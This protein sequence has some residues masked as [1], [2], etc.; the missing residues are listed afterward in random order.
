MVVFLDFLLKNPCRIKEDFHR[1]RGINTQITPWI[2][3]WWEIVKRLDT[4]GQMGYFRCIYHFRNLR[5]NFIDLSLTWNFICVSIWDNLIIPQPTFLKI[6]LTGLYRRDFISLK[7]KN[8]NYPHKRTKKKTRQITKRRK[9]FCC[10]Q[11][12]DEGLSLFTY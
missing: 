8:Y 7:N 10:L 6:T 1:G 4:W 11:P 3:L 5:E 12:L 2:R 9:Y